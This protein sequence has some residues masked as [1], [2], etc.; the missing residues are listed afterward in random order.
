MI[1]RVFFWIVLAMLTSSCVHKNKS[2]LQ[3][4]GSCYYDKQDNFVFC[5]PLIP[6][7]RWERPYQ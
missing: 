2:K 1:K 4:R 7:N 3:K 6:H 5:E